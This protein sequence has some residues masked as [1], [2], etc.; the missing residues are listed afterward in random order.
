MM[1]VVSVIW[2]AL[3]QLK[4]LKSVMGT[5]GKLALQA[6]HGDAPMLSDLLTSSHHSRSNGHPVDLD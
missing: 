3:A 1:T 4:R 5:M 2:A 6:M